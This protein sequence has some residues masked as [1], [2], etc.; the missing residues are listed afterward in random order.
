MWTSMRVHARRGVCV[1]V[2][3]CVSVCMHLCIFICLDC[4]SVCICV[5]VF[6]CITHVRVCVCACACVCT[7][8]HMSVQ[9][10]LLL[11]ESTSM[12]VCMHVQGY[13][14]EPVTRTA[15]T[16]GRTRPVHI[17][18]IPITL[19]L[20][21]KQCDAKPVSWSSVQAGLHNIRQQGGLLYNSLDIFPLSLIAKFVSVTTT[22]TDVM[23][24]YNS[25]TFEVQSHLDI[26][27]RLVNKSLTKYFKYPITVRFLSPLSVQSHTCLNSY[28]FILSVLPS[29]VSLLSVSFSVLTDLQHDNA[30]HFRLIK[31][32]LILW[33][34]VYE[35]TGDWP[36]QL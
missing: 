20:C 30:N 2:C 9:I 31:S 34:K 29:N 25:I 4:V 13:W 26:K 28:N 1:C 17:M 23:L 35:M 19:L 12:C 36:L 27:S 3:V 7:H 16:T 22:L 14:L 33:K 10:F 21:V 6:V 15:R 18:R 8:M 24:S 5:Y 32:V 11:S